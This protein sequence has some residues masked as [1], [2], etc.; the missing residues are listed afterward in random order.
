MG[1]V[2]LYKHQ[3]R[4]VL[5]DSSRDSDSSPFYSDSESSP[6]FFT[7]TW[8]RTRTQKS[9]LVTESC[10]SPSSSGRAVLRCLLWHSIHFVVCFH[11]LEDKQMLNMWTTRFVTR[12]HIIFLTRTL[13]WW[14]GLGLGLRGDDS[15][16][17]SDFTTWTGYGFEQFGYIRK[18]KIAYQARNHVGSGHPEDSKVL[19]DIDG[20]HR[21]QLLLSQEHP[22]GKHPK[23]TPSPPP[24]KKKKMGTCMKPLMHS[25]GW[26]AG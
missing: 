2:T 8:T 3:Y 23:I 20:P 24:K 26:R 6:V 1:G 22:P 5:C 25:S 12:T 7:W 16:S 14:L 13:R 21:L 11:V 10:P 15:D 19:E 9:W 18:S 4:A 17:D